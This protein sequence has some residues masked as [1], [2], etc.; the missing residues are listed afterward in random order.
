MLGIKRVLV[1]G[2]IMLIAAI[3]LFAK[4]Q[5]RGI[6]PW[7]QMIITRAERDAAP[8]KCDSSEGEYFQTGPNRETGVALHQ[9]QWREANWVVLN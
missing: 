2:G 1:A 7:S 8:L 3:D 5:A 9:W 4:H 6:N